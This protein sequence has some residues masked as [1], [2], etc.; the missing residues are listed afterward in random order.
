MSL[1]TDVREVADRTPPPARLTVEDASYA[2]VPDA[3]RYERRGH[4]HWMLTQD[5]CEPP[6]TTVEQVVGDAEINALLDMAN[7][8]SFARP[9]AA[10]TCAP[11][12][13]C[14]RTPA[15]G[16]GARCPRR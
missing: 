9:T 12:R 7:P 2:A 8:D 15:A 3:W 5:R 6:G 13:C 14:P 11:C 10:G 4:W 16:W 1:V